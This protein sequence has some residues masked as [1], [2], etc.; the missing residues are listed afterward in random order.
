M[1]KT[2]TLMHPKT[3]VEYVFEVVGKPIKSEPPTYWHPG[4]AAYVEIEDICLLG[5]N[6]FSVE[7]PRWISTNNQLFDKLEK[8]WEDFWDLVDAR[9]LE[10]LS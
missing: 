1:T 9:F 10:G 6:G 3:D 7:P 4:R 8:T 2:V 5:V